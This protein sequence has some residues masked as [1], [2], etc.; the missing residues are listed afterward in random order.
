ME[1]KRECAAMLCNYEVLQLL[2]DL[3]TGK[4]QK[5]PNTSQTHLATVSYE[6]VK[7]LENTPCAKQTPE[8]ISKFM[9]AIQPYNLTKSEKLQLLNQRPRTAVEIQLI[10]EES[11]ERLTEDQIY[12]LLDVM[13]EHLPGDEEEEMEEETPEQG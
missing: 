9:T 3:K 7:Y 8:I 2:S 1:V 11:E 13:K 6:T 12:E 10:V 5:K 4:G